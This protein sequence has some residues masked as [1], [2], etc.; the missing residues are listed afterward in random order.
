MTTR[1]YTLYP[2]GRGGF[3]NKSIAYHGT[4]YRVAAISIKQAYYLAHK[5]KWITETTASGIVSIY[6]R[7]CGHQLWDGCVGHEYDLGLGHADGVRKINDAVRNHMTAF[8]GNE[9]VE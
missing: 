4:E 7:E 5:R 3:T 2:S 8:H 1:I 9:K 6:M